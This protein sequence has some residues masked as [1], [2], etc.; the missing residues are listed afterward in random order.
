MN[1]NHE[2]ET[3]CRLWEKL[4]ELENMLFDHYGEKFIDMHMDDCAKKQDLSAPEDLFNLAKHQK[5]P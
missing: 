2:L 5:M 3:A 1:R 4:C